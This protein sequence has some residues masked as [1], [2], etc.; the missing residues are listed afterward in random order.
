MVQY[1]CLH[2]RWLTEEEETRLKDTIRPGDWP[3][4]AFAIRTGLRQREQFK[5]RWENVNFATGL[6]TIPRSKSGKLRRI[7]MNDTVCEILSNLPSRGRSLYV[8]PS[9]TGETPLDARNFLHRSF[10]PA[11]KKAKIDG[12]RWH[13][14]RHT[15]ASRL[16]MESVDLYTVKE[17]MGHQSTKMTEGYAHLSAA[18]RHDAV[19]ATEREGK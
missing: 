9:A 2:V 6:I 14:L 12:L 8:F 16:V 4:V 5:L 1:R 18:H 19:Q 3:L 7:E 10:W 17:L 11:V 15:S 13:D